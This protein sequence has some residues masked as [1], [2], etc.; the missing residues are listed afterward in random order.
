MTGA[1]DGF[2]G[3]KYE[4]GTAQLHE[5]NGTVTN[6]TAAQETALIN[7]GLNI[8]DQKGCFAYV[9]EV[10][11]KLKVQMPS[12]TITK[13]VGLAGTPAD[14]LSGS[15]NTKP[16]DTLGWW[17]TFM[18]TGQTTLHKVNIIDQVPVGLTVV[19]GS[20][21]LITSVYPNGYVFP[22]SAIQANGRQINVNISDYSPG[23]GAYIA[24]RTTVNKD[25][26]VA[27]GA[28]A[29]VNKAYATP[30]GYGSIYN[31]ANANVN[32]VCTTTTTSKTPTT[33]SQLPN[34]GA[35][36]V[37]GMFAG[38]SIAGGI[39]YRLFLSRRLARQ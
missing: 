3:L 34:T 22:D 15:V 19:P 21:K 35:G 20:V 2:F 10:T 27:C 6:L 36:N 26:S 37:I 39:G 29:L 23:A 28:H 4:N 17:V 25:A 9:R 14:K 5:Q 11:F 16:G 13:E 8:G 12:Y 31:T 30:E 33:P 32:K 24:Y 38:A 1:N 18:N 7:G